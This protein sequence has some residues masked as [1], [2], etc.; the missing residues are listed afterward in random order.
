MAD[1]PTMRIPLRTCVRCGKPIVA[2]MKECFSCGA[3]IEE[4]KKPD[5]QLLRC[6]TCGKELVRGATVCSL[7]GTRLRPERPLAP[8]S[9]P[10]SG[11]SSS[12]QPPISLTTLEYPEP[13]LPS[14]NKNSL[15]DMPKRMGLGLGT[16]VFLLLGF[17]GGKLL[18]RDFAK[19]PSRAER[20]V[21]PEATA[22][23]ATMPATT[24]PSVT[25]PVAQPSPVAPVAETPPAR[26]L[27]KG[28]VVTAD[29]LM[30]IQ[31]FGP[32]AKAPTRSAAILRERV[33]EFLP[34]MRSLY[35]E[36]L[37]TTQQLL[38]TVIVEFTLTPEGRVSQV[39]SHTTGV[40]NPEFL[41][42]VR[43]LVQEWQFEPASAGAVTVFY[44]LLFTPTELDPFLLIGWSK[45]LLPG[46]YRM[47]GGEPAP[48]RLRP[49]DGEA[50]VG[51][52]SPGLRVD[53]VGSQ[54]GWLSVLSPKGKVGYVR[55]EAL[56]PRIEE[57][58][59]V[60]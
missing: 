35:S 44:P 27:R 42:I 28:H 31:I 33:E 8:G 26:I 40:E 52:V 49:D 48:V 55:R 46:R 19:E 29:G 50:E 10:L 53:V 5:E 20:P 13:P 37:M 21:V 34:S 32:G 7:C 14:L 60:S 4:E 1:E 58:Q 15:L 16:F 11:S 23:A 54:K 51:R 59:P 36:K 25:V 38:G 39:G 12:R 6:P 17:F 9:V 18:F 30:K 57:E 45:D 24:A 2:D 47:L 56:F 41:Q 3:P 22:P 43:S